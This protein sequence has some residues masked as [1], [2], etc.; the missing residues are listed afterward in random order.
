MADM[1]RIAGK[2]PSDTAA[3]I[4]V[5][6]D[7]NLVEEKKWKYAYEK[8]LNAEE[9][10]STSAVV[11]TG[12]NVEDYG[13]ISLRVYSTLDQPIRI[14]FYNDTATNGGS[15]VLNCLNSAWE[16]IIPADSKMYIITPDDI[17][18]LNYL[19]YIKLR[20]VATATPT[21]GNV[22]IYLHKKG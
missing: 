3:G 8:I 18:F 21:T 12:G 11:V 6:S 19:R 2:T 9:I 5:N 13:L 1:M 22:T 4:R 16:V 14:Q 20:V 10:R 17:P 7:G 15:S